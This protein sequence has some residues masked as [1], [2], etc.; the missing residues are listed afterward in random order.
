V[1][2]DRIDILRFVGLAMIIFAHV[3]PPGILFQLRN[4]DV[5]LMVLV[6]GMSFGLSYKA[7]ESY[8]SYIWKRCKRLVFPVWIFLTF[9]FFVKFVFAPNSAE[10]NTKTIVESYALIDGIGYVWIIKV[11]LLVALVSPYLYL[12]NKNTRSHSQ[13][14][15]LIAV[16]LLFYE[17]LRYFSL[18]YIKE[19]AVKVLSLITHY[20]IPFSMVFAIGLRMP[21]LNKNQ[22]LSF[23][24]FSLVLLVLV[25][26]GLFL[27]YGKVIPV[28]QFKYP[29]SIY[30]FSYA[31]FVSCLL[32]VY[33]GAISDF[34][35]KIGM[36]F[37]ILFIAQN[38][39][40]IYL[41]HILL[42]KLVHFHFAIKY[43]IVFGVATAITYVQVLIVNHLVIKT[44]SSD[45]TK[46]NIKTLFTG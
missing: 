39:I 26:S 7:S 1:R 17:L 41:W 27:F 37:I 9:Y 28:Q 35:E 15:L 23:S 11:F 8:L 44:L 19:G 13:Y 33:S 10:L 29:P 38:S 18:P 30:Y 6:S 3:D 22:L 24:V 14:F 32:W 5:P 4:F 40:W 45:N 43:L 2:D 16:S 12:V 21:S 20:I 25:G 31:F 34:I 42:V 46:R 36:K